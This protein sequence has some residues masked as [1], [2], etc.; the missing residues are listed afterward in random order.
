MFPARPDLNDSPERSR[1]FASSG[2]E[3]HLIGTANGTPS[4]A[5][6]RPVVSQ[7][8]GGTW[9]NLNGYTAW[10]SQFAWHT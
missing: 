1:G 3:A 8:F 5:P 4:T 9:P 10:Q 2:S 6:A 7:L